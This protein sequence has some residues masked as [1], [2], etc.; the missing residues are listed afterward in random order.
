MKRVATAVVVLAAA[1]LAAGVAGISKSTATAGTSATT[2]IT[3][4]VGWSARELNEF[5]KVVAEY[6]RA[7]PAVE[8]K[9]VGSISDDKII[10]AIKAGNAPD[11]VSSFSSS[12]VGIYCGTGAWVDLAPFLKSAK[13]DINIFPKT[14][15]YY[16]QY[17]G[18]RCALPLLAD[19]YGFYYNKQLFQEAGLT[20]APRTWGEL[21]T[22]AK[23]L[24]KRNADGSLKV[25]G[26]NPFFGWY[27]NAIANWVPLAGVKWIDAK[28]NS[29]LSKD[30][31]FARLL[32]W[33][34]SLVNWYGHDKLVKF[35]AG[36]GDEW[37]A[38]NAF[39]SGKVAMHLDG[40]W[41]VAFIAAENPKLEYGTAPMPVDGANTS[42]YGGGNVN[43]TII[44]IP[45]GGKNT[46]HAWLL[47]R[48]L[49]TNPTA[50]AKFSNGIRNV[51]STRDSADSKLLKPDS[52]F[53]TFVKI[54]NHP[55]SATT[56]ITAAGAAYLELVGS[57]VTKWQAGRVKNLSVGLRELDKQIDAQRK[58]AELGAP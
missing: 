25:V 13:I 46:T 23:K 56:P 1:A 22:Y 52:N 58:Q 6:D 27:E 3:V 20:R 42:L 10:A 51:P 5:K 40:E 48:Y 2:K 26:F 4:W 45:K 21:S 37:S 14:S 54:F 55:K 31:G 15:Q 12:N 44:G 11:V 7:R 49:T 41:R 38:S 19:A 36:A 34:K 53:E 32:R 9:V 47:V 16:T 17:K 29:T 57:F 18:K 33:Q 43:G 28:G 8:I 39:E 30:A 35:N 24:T 50:L